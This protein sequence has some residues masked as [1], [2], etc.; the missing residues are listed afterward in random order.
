ME[1]GKGPRRPSAASDFTDGG[2][3]SHNEEG[4][5]PTHADAE[6]ERQDIRE[7]RQASRRAP[8]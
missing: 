5:G 7:V 3:D 4:D 1:N 2:A 8:R 6:G